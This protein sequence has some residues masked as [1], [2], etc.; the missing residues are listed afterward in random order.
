V[1][2][3]REFDGRSCGGW[4]GDRLWGR[5]R[6]RFRRRLFSGS[7]FSGSLL[8]R[9]LLTGVSAF[10]RVIRSFSVL[11]GQCRPEDQQKAQEGE[12]KQYL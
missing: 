1:G 2:T 11:V 5:L 7:L 9:S 4:V 12:S 8:G 3:H 6:L 10:L